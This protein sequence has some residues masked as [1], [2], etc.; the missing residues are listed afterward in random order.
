MDI[1]KWL[2]KKLKAQEISET[3]EKLMTSISYLKCNPDK[4]YFEGIEQMCG[5]EFIQISDGTAFGM[6]L[7]LT[8]WSSF[9]CKD[10]EGCTMTQVF[11]PEICIGSNCYFGA[12]NHITA[13]NRIQIGDNLLT[14]KWVTITDNN[15]GETTSD[16]VS[17]PPIKRALTSKGP[18]VIGDNVW[19]G[20]KATILAGVTIGDSAIIAANSVVTQ[21][22]PSCS[23]VAGNPARVIKNMRY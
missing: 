20:D 15:H 14:G 10:K 17:V 9:E 11:S 1:I 6:H 13:I 22:V 21:N 7:F 4:V 16:S 18:V 12:Y 23:V 8:A 19:I 5:E 3:N 2:Y